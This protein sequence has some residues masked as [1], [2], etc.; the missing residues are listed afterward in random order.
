[1][2]SIFSNSRTK[3]GREAELR[4]CFNGGRVEFRSGGSCVSME[5]NFTVRNLFPSSFVSSTVRARPS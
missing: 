1:M 4:D 3:I 2:V 5:D